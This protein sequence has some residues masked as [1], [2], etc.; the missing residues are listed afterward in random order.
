MKNYFLDN[1]T[2]KTNRSKKRVN[3]KMHSSV[4]E[5]VLNIT[6][7]NFQNIFSYKKEELYR[8]IFN[9]FFN[10][11]EDALFE[12]EMF[13]NFKTAC[14][15]KGLR[16][17]IKNQDLKSFQDFDEYMSTVKEKSLSSLNFSH[18]ELLDENQK[19]KVVGGR[20]KKKI[21]YLPIHLYDSFGRFM[22][23]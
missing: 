19:N 21:K 17:V 3:T 7:P 22:I 11:D 23:A 9:Y 10:N 13:S 18:Q 6:F 5:E 20:T 16:F 8:L 14:H 12:I 4:I 2:V 15:I 1:L